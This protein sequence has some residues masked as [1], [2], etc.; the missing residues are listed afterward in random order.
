[1]Q[2]SKT[3]SDRIWFFIHA[4]I[5]AFVVFI[6]FCL[7]KFI[8]ETNMADYF[9]VFSIGIVLSAIE[10]GSRYKDEPISVITCAPGLFYLV[11]NGALCCIGLFLLLTFKIKYAVS[12][13]IEVSDLSTSRVADVIYAA[14]G[15]FLMMRSSF[16]KLGSENSQS[17]IELGLNVLL[18][19]L[20]DIIDRQ[21]DRDQ[22]RRRSSDITAM[23]KNVSY[24][25]LWS[26]VHPF[27]FQVMQNV[28]EE[29]VKAVIDELLIIHASDDCQ[30]AKKL[31]VGLLLYNVV[32]KKLFSSI[33]SDL[34]ICTP[35]SDSPDPGVNRNPCEDDFNSSFSDLVEQVKIKK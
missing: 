25:A 24:Q 3:P 28:S 32:G 33:I 10:L 27:C 6:A 14:L 35:G 18:K 20:I 30:E 19:K 13:S 1:M 8:Y 22:A 7:L 34:G 4:V 2:Y 16:L 11:I 21:V 5:F 26:R 9:F 31:S 29:E 15:T 23:L 17:Q 12:S